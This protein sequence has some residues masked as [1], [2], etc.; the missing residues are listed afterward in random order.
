MLFRSCNCKGG[1]T[2]ES[3]F[4]QIQKK[5]QS[6]G[7]DKVKIAEELEGQALILNA[8][9]SV[10]TQSKQEITDVNDILNETD[11]LK[12]D[13]SI[14]TVAKEAETLEKEVIEHFNLNNKIEFFL[15][16]REV[17][18]KKIEED[19]QKFKEESVETAFGDKRKN[20]EI[21]ENSEKE[22]KE[23]AKQIE[24]LMKENQDSSVSE[25]LKKMNEADI[26]R[27]EK[28][29]EFIDSVIKKENEK[30]KLVEDVDLSIK[31]LKEKQLE[32]NSKNKEFAD[33]ALTL[34]KKAIH[35]KNK[36]VKEVEAKKAEEEAAKKAAEEAAAN[37]G[38]VAPI[39]ILPTEEVVNVTEETT[40]LGEAVI[41]EPEKKVEETPVTEEVVE[42]GNEEEVEIEEETT[43]RGE[44]IIK[45]EVEKKAISSLKGKNKAEFAEKDGVKNVLAKTGG[46]DVSLFAL[47]SK[48]MILLV[49]LFTVT[50]FV[51]K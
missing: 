20:S 51:R 47:L 28:E 46:M 29:I 1:V 24:T 8:K 15:K 4:V 7:E 34:T 39:V 25:A 2:E 27:I 41:T 14:D 37:A 11:I 6:E 50:K 13:D 40:P 35:L 3:K 23:A 36:V 33:K 5:N 48:L 17:S 21:L 31:E 38:I 30:K 45:D 19:Y 43:A 26:E 9:I 42:E 22:K 18:K 10:M 49:G 44:A 16:D 12:S 32:L